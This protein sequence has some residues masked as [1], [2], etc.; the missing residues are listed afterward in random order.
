MVRGCI[1]TK[2]KFLYDSI[3]DLNNYDIFIRIRPDVKLSNKINL[4]LLNDNDKTIHIVC[5][6]VV[7]EL[8]RGFIIEIG[9][10]Y[11]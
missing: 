10:V 3:V 6:I 4:Q 5:S 8:I 11:K 9:Y 1:Y 7:L 2:N